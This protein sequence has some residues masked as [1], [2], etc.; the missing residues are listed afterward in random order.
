[1]IGFVKFSCYLTGREFHQDITKN[2]LVIMNTTELTT[3][4][5]QAF[6][7][8][9]RHGYHSEERHPFLRLGL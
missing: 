6:D 2:I 3:L 7:T 1:M 4:R 5:D 9:S 8:A